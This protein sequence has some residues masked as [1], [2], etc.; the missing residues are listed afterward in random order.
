MFSTPQCQTLYIC[1]K[2]HQSVQNLTEC[3]TRSSAGAVIADRL[4]NSLLRVFV[5]NAIHCD[6]SVSTC[7]L[8]FR[9]C[10]KSKMRYRAGRSYKLLANYQLKPLVQV[11][12][13]CTDPESHNAERY[14]QTDGQNT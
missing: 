2:C 8:K 10:Y 12:S 7:E 4:K 9:R 6:R 1:N 11:L 13:L 3:R 14:R 5:F